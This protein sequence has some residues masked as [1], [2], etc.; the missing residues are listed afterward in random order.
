LR[1]FV[2]CCRKER[3]L[4]TAVMTAIGLCPGRC[5]SSSPRCP[6]G[7]EQTDEC[8]ITDSRYGGSSSVIHVPALVMSAFLH[9]PSNSPA[10][11]TIVK[12]KCGFYR[13]R[14]GLVSFGWARL[15]FL[16]MQLGPLQ[17]SLS[18]KQTPIAQFFL[19]SP[20]LPKGIKASSRSTTPLTGNL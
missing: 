14:L 11:E 10:G 8:S 4:D 2:I 12:L 3:R 5:D 6:F 17:R 19:T 16:G 9:A 15:D 7:T 18:L 1:G 20:L 13:L